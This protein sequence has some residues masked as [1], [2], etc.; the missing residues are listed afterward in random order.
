MRLPSKLEEAIGEDLTL[1]LFE[2]QVALRAIRRALTDDPSL[3]SEIMPGMKLVPRKMTPKERGKV[4]VLAMNLARQKNHEAVVQAAT[5]IVHLVRK[6]RPIASGHEIALALNS[7]CEYGPSKRRR[8][9]TYADVR[10]L[11]KE[12]GLELEPKEN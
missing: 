11:L 5:P 7:K 6:L 1:S 10:R 2:R 12:I 8:M 4:A 3:I 9:W